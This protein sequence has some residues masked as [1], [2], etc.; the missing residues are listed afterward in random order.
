[1]RNIEVVRTI[2]GILGKSEDLIEFVKDRPGHDFR[3]CLNSGKLRNEIGF[4]KKTSVGEGIE[5]TVKWYLDNID[6]VKSKI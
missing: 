2:L 1:M 6:W 5:K 4:V 3:Y